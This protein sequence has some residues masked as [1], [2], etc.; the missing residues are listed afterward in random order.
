MLR[1]GLFAL[2]MMVL[3]FGFVAAD[4]IKGKASKVDEKSITVAEE[5]KDGKSYNFAKGAKFSKEVK[6]VKED[7]KDGVKNEVFAKI[8]KKGLS[9]TIETNKEGEVTEVTVTGKKKK[10]T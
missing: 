1:Q 4:T 10:G 3:C 9:V 8:G 5:G 2:M 6:G 7:L